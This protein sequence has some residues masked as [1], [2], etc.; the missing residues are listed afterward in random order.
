MK[1]IP[2]VL[3]STFFLMFGRLGLDAQT[4]PSLPAAAAKCVVTDVRQVG[5]EKL[6]RMN[7]P[8]NKLTMQ[9]WL[10]PREKADWLTRSIWTN[11][12]PMGMGQDVHISAGRTPRSDYTRP[13][14]VHVLIIAANT[15]GGT[16]NAGK[17]TATLVSLTFH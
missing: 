16:S 9:I 14:P 12:I 8:E 2:R 10:P 4:V 11:V 6:A 5:L 17:V 7:C 15:P 3:F 13:K 1:A